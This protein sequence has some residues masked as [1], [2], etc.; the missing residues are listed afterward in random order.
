MSKSRRVVEAEAEIRL[1]VV[2][3]KEFWLGQAAFTAL[4]YYAERCR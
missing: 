2:Q 3:A 1:S 4:N